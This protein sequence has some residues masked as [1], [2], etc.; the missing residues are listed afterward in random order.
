MTRIRNFAL[1]A[2]TSVFPLVA[3]PEQ[4]QDPVYLNEDSERVAHFLSFEKARNAAVD[5]PLSLKDAIG[6]DFRL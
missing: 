5:C 6:K 4:S 1:K 3:L 2:Y